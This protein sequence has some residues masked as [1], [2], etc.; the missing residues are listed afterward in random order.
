[1]LDKHR[2]EFEGLS[3]KVWNN[4]DKTTQI[5]LAKYRRVRR[6]V[7]KFEKEIEKCRDKIKELQNKS[8]EYNKILT[9]LYGKINHLK[10]DYFPLINIIGYKKNGN[11]SLYWNINIEFKN[12]LRSFYLGSDNKVRLRMKDYCKVGYRVSE[13]KLRSELDYHL[14]DELIDMV[15]ENK[16]DFFN[17]SLDKNELWERVKV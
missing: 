4:L 12:K 1:M 16:D 10:S 17:W 2:M 3:D 9:H 13:K 14:K 7:L 8:R 6:D 15:I 5:D 11:D